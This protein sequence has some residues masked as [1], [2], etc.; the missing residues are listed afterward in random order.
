MSQLMGPEAKHESDAWFNLNT[1][2]FISNFF[3]LLRQTMFGNKLTITTPLEDV[4]S[5]Y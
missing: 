4:A 2:L 1:G 3:V 5:D